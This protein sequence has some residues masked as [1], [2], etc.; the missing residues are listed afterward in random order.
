MNSCAMAM[1]FVIAA[2]LPGRMLRVGGPP[3]RAGRNA[4]PIRRN[5]RLIVLGAAAS[6]VAWVPARCRQPGEFRSRWSSGACPIRPQ[7][8]TA[9]GWNDPDIGRGRAGPERQLR[10]AGVGRAARPDNRA[11]GGASPDGR[12]P[13]SSEPTV[14]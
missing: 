11:I 14:L 10:A 9:A 7:G 1:R 13:G 8:N 4:R 3:A 12:G 2:L 5:A 6:L